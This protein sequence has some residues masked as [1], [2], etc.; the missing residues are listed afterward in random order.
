MNQNLF[1]HGCRPNCNV[2]IQIKPPSEDQKAQAKERVDEALRLTE[3][4]PR[5]PRV[6]KA[7]ASRAIEL[8]EANA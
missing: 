8:R 6:S 2:V 4:P 3:P 7:A 1:S 5:I